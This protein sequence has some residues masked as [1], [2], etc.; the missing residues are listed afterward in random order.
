MAPGKTINREPESKVVLVSVAPEDTTMNAP[1]LITVST[2]DA[3]E[4]TVN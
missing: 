4:W 3:P 1:L 2:A